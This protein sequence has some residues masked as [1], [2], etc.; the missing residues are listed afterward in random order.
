M[1]LPHGEVIII[2]AP[3]CG[4]RAAVHR[5]CCTWTE[6]G[7][8]RSNI[9][10]SPVTVPRTGER[11]IIRDERRYKGN[12]EYLVVAQAGGKLFVSPDPI[13]FNSGP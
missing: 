13:I 8:G 6:I 1:T 9:D 11:C 12:Y 10:A 5:A 2:R 3:G 4:G 7:P